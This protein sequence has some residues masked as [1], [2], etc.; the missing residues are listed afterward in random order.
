MKPRLPRGGRAVG[1]RLALRRQVVSPPT[2]AQLLSIL[3]PEV[4][5]ILYK[6]K[7]LCWDPVRAK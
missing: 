4:R 6:Q 2:L 1:T 3:L 5:I 7:S